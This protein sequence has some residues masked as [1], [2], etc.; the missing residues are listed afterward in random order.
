MMKKTK[1]IFYISLISAVVNVILNYY[2]IPKFGIIGG[3]IATSFSLML[4]FILTLRSC[5][6]LTKIQP[7]KLNYFKSVA[8]GIISLFIK[9][10][11]IMQI[12]IFKSI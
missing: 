6:K 4:I 5:Y 12:N 8:S 3:S 7:L 10:N 2:L 11:E 9:F 1:L